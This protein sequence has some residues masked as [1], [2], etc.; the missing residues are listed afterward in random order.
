MIQKIKN[1]SNIWGW[2]ECP[3]WFAM[4]RY[5]IKTYH[6]TEQGLQWGRKLQRC[7]KFLFSPQSDVMWLCSLF[8]CYDWCHKKLIEL[9]AQGVGGQT[10]PVRSRLVASHGEGL[11]GCDLLIVRHMMDWDGGRGRP[12]CA[13]PVNYEEN[14]WRQEVTRGGWAIL[15]P[16]DARF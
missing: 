14:Q 15:S 6:V 1:V 3:K 2:C 10:H 8:L 9:S 7:C 11:G 13:G 5:Q 4:S 12:Q 16:P